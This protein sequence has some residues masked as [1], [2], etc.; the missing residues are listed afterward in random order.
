MRRRRGEFVAELRSK[1][2]GTQFFPG[3]GDGFVKLP[4]SWNERRVVADELG[5]A[6][7]NFI[8]RVEGTVFLDKGVSH[9]GS[10]RVGGLVVVGVILAL[11]QHSELAQFRNPLDRCAAA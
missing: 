10:L 11:Y 6:E 9:E 4:R 8:E 3:I 7:D 2:A 1:L 5:I